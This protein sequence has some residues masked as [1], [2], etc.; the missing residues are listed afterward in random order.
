MLQVETTAQQR[1]P[2]IMHFRRLGTG[3]RSP[4]RQPQVPR[5]LTSSHNRDI[6]LEEGKG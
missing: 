6:N 2:F 4:R 3:N 5:N 1:T